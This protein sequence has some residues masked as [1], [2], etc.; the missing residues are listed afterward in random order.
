MGAADFSADYCLVTDNPGKYFERIFEDLELIEAA[1]GVVMNAQDEY[2]FI[3]RRDKWDLPKG[4][5]DEGES[6]AKAA[7]REVEE[8]CGLKIDDLGELLS[9]TYHVYALNGQLIL[10]KT[11]WYRMRVHGV[12]ELVPQVEEEITQAVWLSKAELEQ[13]KANTYPLILDVMQEGGL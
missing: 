5:I 2:L 11:Y 3:F 7:V 4:K 6:P 10:K 1:G 8:E 13:I 12:P 9:E